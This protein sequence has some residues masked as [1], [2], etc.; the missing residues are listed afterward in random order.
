M[1]IQQQSSGSVKTLCCSS[2]TATA[3]HGLPGEVTVPPRVPNAPSR[4]C[5]AGPCGPTYRYDNANPLV[6]SWGLSYCNVFPRITWPQYRRVLPVIT[7][8]SWRF[9]SQLHPLSPAFHP[10]LAGNLG[11]PPAPVRRQPAAIGRLWHTS[12]CW[13]FTLTDP[14]PNPNPTLSPGRFLCYTPH[15][16]KAR[17]TRPQGCRFALRLVWFAA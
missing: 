5:R 10:L 13:S 1:K 6:P 14:N 15:N 9:N 11:S 17:S 7:P 12:I 8:P 3:V 4:R 16:R 2:R